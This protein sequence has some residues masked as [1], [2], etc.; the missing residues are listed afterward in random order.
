MDSFDSLDSLDSLLDVFVE[1]DGAMCRVRGFTERGV[2]LSKYGKLQIVS[3][4]DFV[5]RHVRISADAK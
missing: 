5:K 1:F 3:Q 4:P 2:L